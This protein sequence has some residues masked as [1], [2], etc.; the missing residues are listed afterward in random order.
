MLTAF[1]ELLWGFW[2]SLTR[3]FVIYIQEF[4]TKMVQNEDRHILPQQSW[5][6]PGHQQIHVLQL[7]QKSI[8]NITD[9]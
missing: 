4:K 3:H 8:K 9:E 1:Y 2:T 5:P 6:N 7:N